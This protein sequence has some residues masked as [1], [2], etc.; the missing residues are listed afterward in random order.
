MELL[1]AELRTIAERMMR[2]ERG[3]HTLQ[4]TALV[5]EAFL[6]LVDAEVAST[7]GHLYFLDAAAVTMRRVLVDH[8]RAAR[9]EKRG[10]A[11]NRRRVTLQGVMEDSAGDDDV[12]LAALDSA[13]RQ[14]EALS[15]RQ[16]KVV[17]LRFFAGMTGDQIAEH[18]EVSRSSVTRD[19]AFARAWL[20]RQMRGGS[21]G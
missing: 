18:L 2:R 1:Y 13:L 6:R 8:A 9:T 10:G 5:H 16:A 19:L 7:R 17:E 15:S 20:K 12:D 11:E 21:E 14:L 3:S 4:P